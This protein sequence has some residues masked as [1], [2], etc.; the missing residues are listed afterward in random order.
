[1]S[2]NNHNANDHL[3]DHEDPDGWATW[4]I[5]LGGAVITIATITI[6][7]G[8]YYRSLMSEAATKQI[9]VTYEQRDMIK[10]A[11]KAVLEESAHWVRHHDAETGDS[12]DQLV[13]P[14]NDAMDII[15]GNVK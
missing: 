2:H 14:I 9:N 10:A 8:I 5:G 4:A 15:A 11:Q 12:R 13:I 7:M 1:M 6:S 3:D